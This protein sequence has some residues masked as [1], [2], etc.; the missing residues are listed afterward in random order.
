[1]GRMT[2]DVNFGR[3]DCSGETTLLRIVMS[4]LK[5]KSGPGPLFSTMPLLDQRLSTSP[6]LLEHLLRRDD[7]DALFRKR[8]RVCRDN[9]VFLE[10]GFRF[11]RLILDRTRAVCD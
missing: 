10:N 2:R 7:L 9:L 4:R 5:E 8:Q 11:G 6:S 1:M 3:K